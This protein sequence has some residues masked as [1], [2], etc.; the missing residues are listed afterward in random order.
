MA[1][2]PQAIAAEV[3]AALDAGRQITPFSERGERLSPA[4]AYAVT[5]ELRRLRTERGEKQAG[6]KIGFTNRGI[7]A[8]YGVYAPIWGDIYDTTIIDVTPGARVD[9]SSLP[10]P[11]IEPEIVLGI[12]GEPRAGMSLEETFATVGWIA[13]G[14][15]IVQT[16]FR[17]W[18]F[19]WTDCVAD[20]GLH[21]RLLIGPRRTVEPRERP[22]LLRALSAF[23]IALSRDGTMIGEG[24][25]ANALDG[26]V[27]ALTHLAGVL[28]GDAL[29]PPLRPGEIVTTGT[30]TPAFPIRPGER[31]AT[32]L[33]CI[34]L[35]GLS[36]EF[37]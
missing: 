15:E 25:G 20:N 18:R 31:W 26:P 24:S 4:D 33:D 29:N 35:P 30:L 2:G 16:Q 36:V 6:R 19:D 12:A 32:T 13:H 17:D 11:R 34:D 23:R 9:I 14:F 5:A 28:A 10:Q 3:L 22:A 1:A 21:G 37:C 27:H 8:E 7:W